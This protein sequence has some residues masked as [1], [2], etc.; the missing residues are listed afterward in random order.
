MLEFCEGYT[1]NHD[2]VLKKQCG[3]ATCKSYL[4]VSILYFTIQSN[5]LVNMSKYLTIEVTPENFYWQKS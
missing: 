5:A 3:I 2:I 4:E 1:M